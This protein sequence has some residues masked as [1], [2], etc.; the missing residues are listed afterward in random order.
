MFFTFLLYLLDARPLHALSF[1]K[2]Y[3]YIRVDVCCWALFPF[4]ESVCWTPHKGSPKEDPLWSG[5]HVVDI[6]LGKKKKKKERNIHDDVYIHTDIRGQ[7]RCEQVCSTAVLIRSLFFSFLLHSCPGVTAMGCSLSCNQ[8]GAPPYYCTSFLT[9]GIYR[10]YQGMVNKGKYAS[11][12]Q[13][14]DNV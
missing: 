13:K 4:A 5:T 2:I 11:E 12:I 6:A 14:F 9:A 1:L 3:I 8:K 10:S 7:K